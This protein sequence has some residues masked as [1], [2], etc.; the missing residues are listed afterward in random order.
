RLVGE[1]AEMAQLDA[2]M[3]HLEKTPTAIRDIID[4]ALAE[5]RTLLQG[6]LLE[7]KLP[8]K[9]PMVSF[10]F[11][12]IREVLMH[13]IENAA[14]YSSAGKPICVSAALEGDT[15]AVSV[16]DQG[17]GI[18]S[19]EQS[20]IFDKFYRGRNQRYAAGGTGMGLAICKVIVEAHGGNIRVV[21]QLGAGSVFT[22]TLPLGV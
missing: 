15:L 6:H 16:A 20:L 8:E 14:K 17:P 4:A 1:A 9:L 3:F 22:F 13:L 5:E 10:D 18:D 2:G 7:V 21:S 19:M 12:R 11:V